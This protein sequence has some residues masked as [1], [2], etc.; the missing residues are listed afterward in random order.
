MITLN[1][2]GDVIFALSESEDRDTVK[3]SQG[4]LM[5]S[6]NIVTATHSVEGAVRGE[7]NEIA[8]DTFSK[9]SSAAKIK[10]PYV[11]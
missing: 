3:S 8:W 10:L 9:S 5:V 6:S 2:D 11:L 7:V 1:W 4:S